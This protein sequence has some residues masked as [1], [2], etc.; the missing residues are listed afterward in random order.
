MVVVT[1]FAHSPHH[2]LD[3][4]HRAV[5]DQAEVDGA[6]AHQ[7]A[8]KPR[9][10]HAD[11][12]SQHRQGHRQ[13]HDHTGTET[14]QKEQQHQDHQH[15]ALDQILGQ[16]VDGLLHQLGAVVED[17]QFH[18][19]GQGFLD[20]RHPFL[21]RLHHG[22]GVGP[23]QQHHHAHH[24]LALAVAGHGP[25]A[26]QGFVGHPGDVAQVDGGAVL[27][28]FQHDV[29]NVFPARDQPLG[30]HH[31]LLLRAQNQVAAALVAVVGPQRVHHLADGQAEVEH[32][33][34]VGLHLVGAGLA[35]V[36][37]HLDHARHTAQLVGDLPVE[38]FAQ[39]HQRVVVPRLVPHLKLV[40][41]T[42]PGGDGADH[43]AGD[44]LGNLL[45][46]LR[47]ALHHLLPRPEDVGAF[48]ED[49]RHH[50]QA[51]LRDRAD[52]LHPGDATHGRFHREGDELLRLLGRQGGRGGH[53]LHLHI[54]HI[55][56]G[57]HRQAQ[58]RVDA[59]Q[60][61]Q[62]CGQH[63]QETV[64][65]RPEDPFALHDALSRQGSKGSGHQSPASCSLN[66][67]LFRMKPPET[68]TSCPSPNPWVTSTLPS[69][70]R[71]SFTSARRKVSAD[72]RTK[73]KVWVS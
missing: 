2:V 45:P 56:H 21:H 54:G 42:Q 40:D 62:A 64:F 67:S 73:T 14:A 4:H 69:A 10:L 29:L 58:H 50:R 18:A 43:G 15:A 34:G 20:L 51:E 59:A 70:W 30:A 66:S 28:G 16:R 8:R 57:V 38:R 41:L 6:Q 71:P 53:H 55:R 33:R 17:P 48:L 63:H 9:Q 31:P 39:V 5:D 25:L 37:V 49:H 61:Q 27:P 36:D 13:G 23:R 3:Q 7:V 35:A 1:P 46:R 52:L 68:T 60:H 11:E 12:R 65:Q 72:S 19:L 24:R 47:Q 26:D 32:L 22:A 44:P